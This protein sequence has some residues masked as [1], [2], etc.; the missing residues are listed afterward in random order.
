M[1]C[2][3]AKYLW[4]D[5]L[6]TTAGPPAAAIDGQVPASPATNVSAVADT[7]DAYFA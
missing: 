2:S 5:S 6:V 1:S 7:S 4:F 3:V